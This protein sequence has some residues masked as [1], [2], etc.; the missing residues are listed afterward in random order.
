M[1][2]S[3]YISSS[4]AVSLATFLS[5]SP[6]PSLYCVGCARGRAGVLSSYWCLLQSAACSIWSCWCA[7]IGLVICYRGGSDWGFLSRSTPSRERWCWRSRFW[8]FGAAVVLDVGAVAI[9]V[10]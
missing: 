2:R 9:G 8:R 5:R 6:F 7:R 1:A 10:E 3:K 4:C